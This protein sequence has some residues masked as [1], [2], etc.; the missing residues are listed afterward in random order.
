MEVGDESRGR[1]VAAPSRVTWI[2]QPNSGAGFPCVSFSLG[3]N[4][5]SLGLDE[6]Q[7]PVILIVSGVPA[8]PESGVVE[9]V[10]NVGV[11]VTGRAM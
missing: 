6:S 5:E 4:D 11:V 8:Y 9:V 10:G 1:P 2:L 3:V 7:H